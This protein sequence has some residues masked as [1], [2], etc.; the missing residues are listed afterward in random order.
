MQECTIF[1]NLRAIIFPFDSG[2]RDTMES[3]KTG[4]TFFI[5]FITK[6]VSSH[7]LKRL[8]DFS[9]IVFLSKN[10]H[11]PLLLEADLGLLQQPRCSA[12]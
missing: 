4:F 12:L 11:H 3:K 10:P 7:G 6:F 5:E 1:G 2:N 8:F 9:A